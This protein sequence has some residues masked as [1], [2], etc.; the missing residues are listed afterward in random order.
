MFSLFF[1]TAA[2]VL[3]TGLSFAR[4]KPLGEATAESRS[5]ARK[6]ASSLQPYRQR[7]ETCAAMARRMVSSALGVKLKTAPEERENERR[8]LREAKGREGSRTIRSVRV[9]Y[10]FFLYFSLFGT[11]RKRLAAKQRDEIWDS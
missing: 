1:L 11:E 8:V 5:K 6:C 10:P 2:E 9:F 4:V 3:T 7:P